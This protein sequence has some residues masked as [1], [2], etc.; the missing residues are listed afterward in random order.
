MTYHTNNYNNKLNLLTMKR[1]HFILALVAMLLSFVH[2]AFAQTD[3]VA[4]VGNTEYAT[5]DEAIA[6]WTNNTT[7]T[8]LSDVTL[9]DVVTLN[10]TE[11]HI[12]NLGTYTMTAASGKNAIV[13]KACGTGDSER[14]A[15]TINADAA[16]PGGIY[17]GSKC[18]VYYKYADGG[19]SG[20]DRP[21]IKINGGV[22][23][24]STSTLLTAGIYT[25]GTAAR[26]CATLNIAGGT[27]KCSINGATKSKLIISG[28]VFNYSVGSTGDN[29]AIRKI[30]GGKFKSF[31][32]MTNDNK[33]GKYDKF[34]IGTDMVKYDV[35]VYVDKDGYLCIGG[36]VITE[37]SAQY[38]A[39]ASNYSKWSSHLMQSSAAEYGLFYED[40]DMAIAKHGAA[41]VTVYEHAELVEEL[42]NNAA[43]K[44]FTPVLPSEV[45]TFEVEAIDIEATAEATTKVTFNVEPKNAS[46]AKVS[47]PSA[48]IT[49]RLPVPAAWSGKANVY[50]E[51]TLLGAY[52]I[53]EEN[54][55]KYVEVSSANFSEFAVE[56]IVPLFAGEGTEA[57]PYI[58]DSSDK[59]V[60]LRNSVNG[61]EAYAGMYFKLT[62]D[63]A[64]S[65]EWTAIGNGSRSSKSYTGNAFKGVFDGSNNT[66]SGL[67]ITSTTAADAAIG[68][69]GV[70][71]GGTVKNLNLTNVN[72]NVSSSN[73][74]GGAIG[75]ML[76]GATAENIT[77]SG[78][79]VGHDGVGG[80]AGRLVIDGTIA[81]C[82]NNASV[83][84]NYGGIG[85][86]V[87]KAYYEDGSNT[88]T[89]ANIT[90]CTNKGT[91][92]ATMYAG[93]IAGLARANVS[94]CVNEGAIVG[95]TQTGGIVGQLM[96]AG[97]VSGNE[98]KA[99]VSGTSHVGGIIGDYTQSG[100]YTYNNVSIATNTNRGEISATGDCAAILGCNNV[101]G[102]TAMTATGN[103][104]Y[105][106]VEGLALFGNP[107]DMVIDATNKFIVPVAQVGTETYYT[108]AEAAAAAQAGSEIKLLANIDGDITVPA[109]VTLN[110]NGFAISGGITAAGEITFAGVTKVTSF[111]VKNVNTVVNIPAGA[112][113]QLTGTGRMVI[114]HGCTFNITGSIADAKTANVAD[115][116]PSLVMPGASF[117]GAGVTFNV[118]N[119]YISAPS[120]Y[121]SSSK[122]ASGTF[123]FNINNS[124]WE[125]AGKLAFESQ[126]TAATVNFDLIESVLNTGSHLV[127]GVSRGEV[128][129]D[130]SNVNVGKSNQIEN[131]STMTIK[132]GSVVNGAV[133]TSSNAINPGTI[134]VE[135]A[136]YAVT[137][138]FSGAAEGTG[139]L[140]IK[141]GAN[142]SVG[143]IKAGANVTVDAEGMAAGDEINF[144]AN[145]SQFTGTLSVINNDKLEASIVNGKVVLAAK[146]AAKIGEQGY[147]TI[148]DAVAAVKESETITILAG[149]YSEGTIKLP[150]TLK[151]VTIK[152]A[153]G[154]EL[155]DM[156]ISAA[157]GNAYSYEGLT[158]DGITFDNSRIMM[159]GWRNGDETIKDFTVTNCTFKNLD[160]N[161]NSAPVHI[162]KDAAEAVNGFTFTNN[163]IDGATGGSKSGIYA[164]V[165]GEVKVE[166][167]IINNVSFRPYVIQVTTDDGIA[168]NFTVKGNTFSGSAVGRAQGLGNNAEGTDNVNLVVS[169]NI[170]KGITESQQICY[171]NFNPETTTADLSKNY[172]DIDI[173]AN[174]SKI[175]FNSA[176]A[177]NYALRD[178]NVFPIYTALN[179]NGTINT[180]SA[181]TPKFYIAKVGE[182]S[183]ET[184][185]EAFAAVTDDA[186]TVVVLRDVTENLTGAYLRGNITTENGVKVTINLTNSD[187]VACPDTF[188]IGENVTLKVPALF[189]YAGGAQ[190]NGTVIADAYYQRYGGTKLTINEPGSMT[191]TSETC[192]IRYMDGDANAGIYINGDNNDETI[193]LNLAVAYFYQGMI[194]AKNANIK[195]GTY[196]QTN[197]TD[198]QGSANLVLDNSKLV[199]SV[200]D[201][202]AKATGNSTV[203]LTNGS[204]IDAKN[205]G[206]TYGD[207]TALSV[208]A[209][210]KIIGKNGE[211]VMIPVAKIGTTKYATLEDA[212]NAVQD[213]ETIILVD[214]VTISAETAGYTD[215]TYTDGVRY[216]GDKSF[217]VDFNGKTVTDD[218][219][220]N[221]YLIYINNKGEKASE[222]TF[223][224]GSI[225]SANGC[226]SAVCVNSS[227]A[228][229]NVVLNLNGMNITNSND[230]VYSGNPVVRVRTLATV[231]VND[232]TIITSNGASYGVAANTDGS[233]VNINE[234]A[235]IVQQNSGTTG[236]NSVFAAVGGKG[237]INIKGGTITSD[238]YGVHTMTTGTPV[239]NISG[240]TITAPVALKSSTNG[241]NGELATINVTGGTINGTL[242]TYTDNGKIVVSGGT[243]SEAVAEEYCAEGFV[244]VDNADGTY[245][246]VEVPKG[247]NFNGYTGTDG[248]WGEV[249]GNARESFVIKVLDANDNVMG[250]T[251][252]NNV[253]GIIDGDVNVS[254]NLKFNATAN[255]DE[256]WT[257]AWT[258]APTLNNMPSKVELWVDGTKVSGGPV[259]LNGPDDINKINVIVTDADGKVT[260]C[261][262][263]VANALAAAK[264]GETVN[265]LWKEGAAPL[266]M[267][268]SVFGKNVTITGTAK[269]DWSKGFLF[270]GRG[271]EGNATVTFD[272]ANLTSASDQATYGIHVSGREKNTTN[273]YDGTLVIKNSTIELDYLINRNAIELDNATLTVKNGFGIAGRPASETESAANATA[274]ISLANS[275]KVVVNNHNG[276]GIG[277][278]ADVLEGFGVMNIDATSAFET[279]Q[280]FVV[281]ANGTMNIAGK[282]TVAGTL[283]NQ[284]AIVLTDAAA[285]LTSSECGNVTTSVQNKVVSYIDGKYALVAAVAKIGD[286]YFATL[287]DA[288]N[289]SPGS[290]WGAEVTLLKDVTL[291]GGYADADEGLRIEKSV[292]INGAG[293]TIDCGQFV[294]GIRIYQNADQASNV[295]FKNINIVNNNAKGRCIDTRSAKINLMLNGGVNLTAHGTNSQPLTIGGSEA[296]TKVT[297]SGGTID[298]G[299]S[300]YAVICFV[301]VTDHINVQSNAVIKGL[302]AFYLK[303]GVKNTSIKLSQSTSIGTNKYAAASGDFGAIVIEGSNNAVRLENNQAVVKAVA[304]DGA[305][306]AAQAAFLFKGSNNTVGYYNATPQVI[307][308]GGQSYF[309]MAKANVTGTKFVKN[310]VEMV[311]EAATRGYQFITVE[312][313]L[314]YAKNGDTVKL[315]ANAELDETYVNEKSLTLDLNGKTLSTAYVAGSTTNHLYAIQ[316]NAELTITDS[317]DAKTGKISARGNFNYGT[318]TLEAG[319]IEAIDGNGGYAVRNYA[320]TF[321]MNGGTIATTYED[322]DVPG[323]GYDASPVRVDEGATFTMNDGVINNVSNYTVAI[324]NYGKTII[325][326]GKATTIHTTLAN[327]GTMIIEGGEFTC[328]GLEGITA[329]ALWAADGTTTIN[330]G[331]FNGKDNYN[332][333]N[334]DASEGAVV[335][336]TGGTFL[337]VHSGSLYG[338]GTITV[339]G[340]TFFDKIDDARCVVGFQAV[341][342]EYG[343]YTVKE[344]G[345]RNAMTFVDGEFTEYVN[346]KDIE[347]GKLTY[348]RANMPNA[349]QAFYVPFEVPVSVLAEQ[350]FDVAYINGVR[351]DDKDKDGNL[352]EFVMEVIYLHYVNDNNETQVDGS[353]KTLKANY[354][355]FVRANK[356]NDDNVLDIELS[357]V[358]LY[359][360]KD[361]T[362]DCTTMTEKY[363]ITGN[364]SSVFINS[365]EDVLKYGVSTKGGWTKIT[366]GATVKPFRFY[367]TLTSRDGSAPVMSEAASEGRIVVRGEE[368]ENGETII[369]DVV[370][371]EQKSEA[372]FDLQGRR[373][374]KPVKGNLYIIN[375]KKVVY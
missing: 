349:W 125:N 269:V 338:E 136:T 323:D 254:W 65:G 153:E 52:T 333:F 327:S 82:T 32:W 13:I 39:K 220:V 23:T 20:N 356:N 97:T 371:N 135:N 67:T 290:S 177:D 18:V 270:V 257:M 41:N 29:T 245:G 12:L 139:T 111:N 343:T 285:T 330:G 150:A 287:Q 116:T 229:Q 84:S 348:K 367:M 35:G 226:W 62:S 239:I 49:F 362:Y 161:T 94:G 328:N 165:T 249:W 90:N 162:N 149:T 316:N 129:I 155:K 301:P 7:L 289:A 223:T 340:G 190:I 68:L 108:F 71:D 209:T 293:Y 119:A 31:G 352:D 21:I 297:I 187:W 172:Y 236:G 80:I 308:E 91:I 222:I 199:V 147:A 110:G 99:K 168:D 320:G 211:T 53:K 17:A 358:K 314:R 115:V 365:S 9:S 364:S 2:P 134:I 279:P 214:N 225:V 50:H 295:M 208:D 317:S 107:E 179:E 137:G 310:S 183:Y 368:L 189:Y 182:N 86:I 169:N 93:G 104:S 259:V 105:Y 219:C 318:L 40:V 258:T 72:I 164:Q 130:N 250:T 215:G 192:I 300:G 142:V 372:I 42:D 357:G 16:N 303:E 213:G 302:A 117:T 178:M 114:G 44:D 230:A 131:R 79:I 347:V 28:G 167:N 264:D 341:A 309:V 54:G 204:V 294:K 305:E 201:H 188:V 198:G 206:F 141:K 57:S 33:N 10:S 234:G 37:L 14:T 307:T 88:A 240:G 203:T 118:T 353:S 77:V 247:N 85:G 283:T 344:T 339:S 66:I 321:T 146:P 243:F 274:T 45:V 30:T 48:A 143:S 266:A 27:F 56:A 361:V 248:I 272:G 202:P 73:L 171:W 176:A 6:A 151:N 22:F 221:D 133:A 319:T 281:T 374:Q 194:N 148:K 60:A 324:D 154:A 185:S 166:N 95:G 275:S 218:G 238:R 156:T 61:G 63:I 261:Q 96:A 196:W 296:M 329:H 101:D 160:D 132:N 345:C 170:F 306:M 92:K 359:A 26:K 291:E 336:I 331:T 51:G 200:S 191:V 370:G 235:T 325:N 313:A 74:A 326:G 228:T 360:A 369:Y 126:S 260:S 140:V 75:M 55:A 59:L 217:T 354:P 373:V 273:K 83:T 268:G 375:G 355:Y 298:A 197:E 5:I 242:E 89:F 121:C 335:T 87:G 144:T 315:L 350:G 152:G 244:P 252:L 224:N 78:A 334:V 34:T 76:N 366:K 122:S 193:G 70:V 112:S 253:G 19:I 120:S 337:P 100:S 299:T 342:N 175:Y 181:F 233:T 231:N 210:S 123:D 265:L 237:V 15:I 43:V 46:G 38:P 262:T 277:Q 267:N 186:Q 207:N 351:R 24:G 1:K 263:T 184:L 280:G 106:F 138:E 292:T 81:N 312:D 180:E 322:G 304:A 64:L 124:I 246:V 195:A 8:L 216:T 69:F 288:V 36:P 47:N 102:F 276:M 205:G 11:H 127:F 255:T 58:I 98:N 241:G 282:A 251:S 212:F 173:V 286:K 271:G 158:F 284:G 346:D 256:Y 113:L 311:P 145:L 163:V 227:A 232:G 4:K 159:T 3:N 363:E 174:P 109:N 157:D 332:G 128:V 278:A 25:I 103:V